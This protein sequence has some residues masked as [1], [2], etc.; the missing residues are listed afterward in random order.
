M[1]TECSTFTLS[2][3]N[4]TEG[5]GR[6]GWNTGILTGPGAVWEIEDVKARRGIKSDISHI[7]LMLQSQNVHISLPCISLC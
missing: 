5:R 2:T 3:W 6:T 7:L 4:C 1:G